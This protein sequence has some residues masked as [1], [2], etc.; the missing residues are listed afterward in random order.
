MVATSTATQVLD[1][2]P[3]SQHLGSPGIGPRGSLTHF[4]EIHHATDP[5]STGDSP[6]GILTHFYRIHEAKQLPAGAEQETQ[7]C[8]QDVDF[9]EGE[10]RRS[11]LMHR[12]ASTASSWATCGSKPLQ[13]DASEA[14][15]WTS[16]ESDSQSS[17]SEA[18]SLADVAEDNLWGEAFVT[19]IQA[20]YRRCRQTKK[21]AAQVGDQE[22]SVEADMEKFTSDCLSESFQ[23]RVRTRAYFLHL[24]GCHDEQ[25]NYYDALATEVK[26][27][28][29]NSQALATR[30][31]D[32]KAFSS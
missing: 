17:A 1:A 20:W 15:S 32:R 16:F 2:F 8:Q 21:A 18:L 29:A 12:E 24:N 14:P 28:Y 26:L 31:G 19:R 13:Q 5:I 4:Y 7:H 22:S 6:S 10:E 11:K 25:K 9:V 23:E 3:A 30:G 27:A